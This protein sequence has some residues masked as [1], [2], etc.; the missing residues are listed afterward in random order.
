MNIEKQLRKLKNIYPSN[1][2][3]ESFNKSNIKSDV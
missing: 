2:T 1:L 3:K